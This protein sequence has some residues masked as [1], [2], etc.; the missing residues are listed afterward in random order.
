MLPDNL[1]KILENYSAE[2]DSL[3]SYVIRDNG[4]MLS[5]SIR[6][7]KSSAHCNVN[8]DHDHGCEPSTPQC[9]ATQVSTLP[10]CGR[11]T[12]VRRKHKSPSQLRHEKKRRNQWKL[13]RVRRK[14]N[15][16][17]CKPNGVNVAIQTAAPV[18]VLTNNIPQPNIVPKTSV[19]SPPLCEH[20]GGVNSDT[21]PSETPVLEPPPEDSVHQV[22]T[23]MCEQ[24]FLQDTHKSTPKP[25]NPLMV[26]S[27]VGRMKMKP[28]PD[29]VVCAVSKVT[30]IPDINAVVNACDI[31]KSAQN[32][33]VSVNSKDLLAYLTG[34]RSDLP[35][36]L[37]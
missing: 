32:N 30:G 29:R 15:K 25:L 4:Y 5:L 3:D 9:N 37:I 14:G 1:L 21:K 12:T 6:W 33:P 20:D 27:S 36:H 7:N 18:T 2:Y 26:N 31:P 16:Q 13:E 17:L 22:K 35:G 10:T 8:K 24:S 11:N 28:P 23:Q 34:Q 19:S